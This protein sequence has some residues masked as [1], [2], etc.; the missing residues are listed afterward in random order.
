LQEKAM[1]G[2]LVFEDD[3]V[4]RKPPEKYFLLCL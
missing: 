3:V 1:P 4:E 2:K